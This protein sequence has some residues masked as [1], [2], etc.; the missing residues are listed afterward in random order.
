MA[1]GWI[2]VIGMIF[3][4][5][6]W[7]GSVLTILVAAA[8]VPSA[9]SAA[10]ASLSYGGGP[11]LHSSAP[12]LV[13]WTPEGESIPASSEA[14]LERYLADAAADS[15][16]SDDV[17]AVLRQ[18]YDRGGFAD[19]RQSFDPARQV[20][21]DTHPY[22]P[23]VA[24]TCPD[25]SAALPTC[26]SEDQIQ[27]E[28]ERLITADRLP[29]D[30][31]ASSRELRANAPLY[32]V[33]LPA[34]VNLCQVFGTVCADRP[35]GRGCAFHASLEDA[36]GA[37]VLYAP[38]LTQCPSKTDG[39]AWPKGYQLD[40]TAAVQEPNGDVA[41]T[42]LTP[43]SHELSEAT[44]DPLIGSGW[45][46][47][48][49]KH[50]EGGDVCVTY[51]PFN[52]AKGVNPNAYAPTL[53]GSVAAGTLFDQLINGHEY[54]TQSQW[55]DGNGTCELRP[56][57]GRITPRFS[58]SPQAHPLGT[59][60]SFNPG[61]STSKNTESSVTWSFGDGSKPAFFTG[62]GALQIVQH[63]YLRAGRYTVTLTLVDNRGNLRSTTRRLTV[64]PPT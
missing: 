50:F 7:A 5:L 9:A 38:I 27:S 15:E 37:V 35:G 12:Y 36:R 34:D 31:R 23:R 25:V 40:G 30:G 11:V 18:Y 54:Y 63:R 26:I 32:F 41:D 17:F 56:A 51:G 55:S 64:N 47:K 58:V 59:K 24:F 22:P 60:L 46:V 4:G 10:G 21:V 53:G 13:F 48:T 62:S 57:P 19:Y 45:F 61:A 16:R 29:T 39:F 20:I 14:L 42:L 52:P 8:L 28:L 3:S 44:T 1:T 49:G 43:L 33:L 2:G 6:R